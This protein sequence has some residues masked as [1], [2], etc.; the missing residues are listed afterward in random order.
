[1]VQ[2]PS[3]LGDPDPGHYH[4]EPK[5]NDLKS[6]DKTYLKYKSKEHSDHAVIA[7][8]VAPSIPARKLAAT[9]YTGRGFD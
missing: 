5:W 3:Y 6:I 7:N 9:A 4:K 1:M 2:G 8:T